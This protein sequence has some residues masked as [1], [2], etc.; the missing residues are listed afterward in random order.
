MLLA[1]QILETGQGFFPV[2]APMVI[3]RAEMIS[4]EEFYPTAVGDWTS[5]F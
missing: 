5:E 4:A 3:I 1:W 2:R